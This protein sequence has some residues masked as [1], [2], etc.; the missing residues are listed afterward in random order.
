MKRKKGK[1]APIDSR[2]TPPQRERAVRGLLKLAKK[3]ARRP[4]EKA[5][6]AKRRPDADS[7]ER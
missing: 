1:G 2:L 5:S 7:F 6:P 3:V 4:A